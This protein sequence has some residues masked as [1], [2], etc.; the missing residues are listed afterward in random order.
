MLKQKL[1]LWFVCCFFSSLLV[2]QELDLAAPAG[3]VLLTI[4]GNITQHNQNGALQLDREQL[5]S[6]E[7]K[8]IRTETRWT[9][10]MVE[11][12]GPLL[13][14]VLA[15]AGASGSLVSAEAANEYRIQIPTVDFADY[16]VILA[17]EKNGKPM[18]VR[19]KG[20][21][22]VIY[23]WSDHSELDVGEYYSR[24]IWQL[25]KLDVHD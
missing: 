22:W 12:K 19:T 25:V 5:L 24:S 21:L 16:D 18:T 4:G 7:Q 11:F 10:G 1:C 17:M 15:A 3:P 9:Q 23:P 13:R 20:P 14:D 2:A 8:V 6:F